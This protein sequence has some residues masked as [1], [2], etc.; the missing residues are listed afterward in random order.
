MSNLSIEGKVKRILDEQVISER[1]KKREFVIETEEQYPQVLVFQLV[2]DKTNLIDQIN[3]GDKIEVFF[4]LRGREWQKDASS[5]IR[6]FNTLDAWRIQKVESI[7]GQNQ[8]V[9]SSTEPIE[10]AG[11][12]DD[13]PF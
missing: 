5:E 13:L 6:V 2:Q 3:L 1:F 10:P 11:P 8:G 9:D 12:E 7:S 4:N